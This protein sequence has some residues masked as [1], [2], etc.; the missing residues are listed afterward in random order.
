MDGVRPMAD[1]PG[2][3]GET[4][5]CSRQIPSVEGGER[6]G[7]L[8]ERMGEGLPP[9][10]KRGTVANVRRRISLHGQH[11]IPRLTVC[12]AVQCSAS[13]CMMAQLVAT[14]HQ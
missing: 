5:L 6:E 3:S 8:L 1:G 13:Q 11:F 12:S 2:Q 10:E 9:K 4:G 14:K 7:L